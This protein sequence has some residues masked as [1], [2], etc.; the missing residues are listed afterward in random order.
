MK[1]IA[2]IPAVACVSTALLLAVAASSLAQTTAATPPA[3]GKPATHARSTHAKKPVV[4]APPPEPVRPPDP[5]PPDWPA[6]ASPVA[7]SVDWSGRLLTINA[8][9]SSLDQ[10]LHD[11]S[12][13]TGLK[14][15]GASGDQRIYGNFGPAPARE[16]LA[17]LLDGSGY[18]ILMIGDQG[19]GTPRQ[20]V[21]TVKTHIAAP[22]GGQANA[23][24]DEEAEEAPEQPE[25]PQPGFR[26]P[27][28]VQPPGPGRT[29]EQFLQEMQQRH[30]QL[31]PDQ[32]GQQPGQPP[33]QQQPNQ[34]PPQQ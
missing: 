30:Q 26:R 29:P 25:Q 5:P 27:M 20:L 32:P 2:S 31:G 28:Q 6:K 17:S 10:I 19:E 8:A 7:A 34:P 22:V 24:G 15:E 12:T 9:N 14:V 3:T 1:R 16:V 23:N 13:A 33:I 11:V 18:N 21:L 4:E